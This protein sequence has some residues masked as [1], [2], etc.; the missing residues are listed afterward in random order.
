M[1]IIVDAMGGDNAPN[2]IVAG[3]VSAAKKYGVEI[4]LVGREDAIKPLIPQD[5]KGITIMNAE[6]VITMEDDPMSVLKSKKDSSMA[7]AFRAL[8]DGEGDAVVTA[9]NSGAVLAGGT[10]IVKRIKGIRRAAFAPIMPTMTGETLLIDSGA[11]AECTP[12][13][14]LQFATM[15]THYIKAVRG[16]ENP[17]VGLLNNGAEEHKGTPMHQEAYKLLASAPI[18]F[19]GNVEGRDVPE[20]KVDV[21]VADGFSGNVLLK[22]FEGVGKFF[23]KELKIIFGKNLFTKLATLILMSGV[24]ALKKKTDHNEVG[25][26]PLLGVSKPVFKA[27]G[28]AIARTIENAIGQAIIYVE[29]DVIGKITESIVSEEKE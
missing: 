5:A 18:N 27:H 17:K 28:S 15:G 2:E 20:G 8:R 22:T 16:V 3:A 19:A 11:N 21:V 7:Y 24:K 25:G 26:A 13:Y 9:G 12:E 14:L 29:Q 10:M 6:Q 4:L 23:L 1:R